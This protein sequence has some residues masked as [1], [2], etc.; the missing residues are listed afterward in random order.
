M[1]IR[2]L[3]FIITLVTVTIFALFGLLALRRRSLDVEEFISHRSQVGEGMAIATIV[4]SVIGAWLL[5]SPA[6]AA[7]WA[8][9]PGII[10]YGVGQAAPLIAFAWI[11]PRLRQLMPQGH[12]LTEYVWYRFGAG[13][14]SFTVIISIFYMF[15]FL[16]AELTGI[17]LAL[18]L[19]GDIPLVWTVLVVSTATLIYTTYGGL[20]ATIFTDTLQFG[21]ILPLLLI[22][23]VVIISN[24]GGLGAAFAPLTAPD[25]PPLLSLTFGPGVEFGFALIIAI[26]TANLFHQGFWQRVYA[27]RDAKTLARSYWIAGLVVIP[28]VILSGALGLMAAGYGVPQEQASVALFALVNEVMPTWALMLVLILS[29]ALVMSSMDTLINGITSTITSDLSRWRSHL[30]SGQLLRIARALTVIVAI[31]SILIASQGYSVLYLF[32]VADLV[33]AGAVFPVFYGLYSRQFSSNAALISS[34][35]GIVAGLLFFPKPDF[36]PLVPIPLAGSFL[37]SFGAALVISTGLA[38]ILSQVSGTRQAPYDFSI[39][40]QRVHSLK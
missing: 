35:V 11:G 30:P 8:G 21:V 22:I 28:M 40:E 27:C 7:T 17:A 26:L 31:P 38:L 25:A 12:S 36:T 34:A 29:L 19:I 37:M 13:M 3:A 10:G 6:E 39:L 4:A 2:S 15:V 18:N 5:L 23:F 16:S 1:S 14:Y 24:L 32:L 33:C 20:G 9:V